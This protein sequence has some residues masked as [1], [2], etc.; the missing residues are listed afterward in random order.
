MPK[1]IILTLA[2]T[3]GIG[4]LC[5]FQPVKYAGFCFSGSY[6]DISK[7]YPYTQIILQESDSPQSYL[8]KLFYDY[9]SANP[10]LGNFTLDIE[11]KT[12]AT[13]SLAMALNREEVAF[14]YYEKQT[15]AIYNLG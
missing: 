7:N 3:L 5:A 15:K 6:A 14:E 8:D 1:H 13:L 10:E 2:L 11:H 9:F 4:L 12:K